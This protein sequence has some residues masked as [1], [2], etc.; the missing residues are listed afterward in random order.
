MT[1][2]REKMKEVAKEA[3]SLFCNPSDQQH[4]QSTHSQEGLH[5]IV[6]IYK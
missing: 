2:F 4:T 6:L 1:P 5:K 3:T